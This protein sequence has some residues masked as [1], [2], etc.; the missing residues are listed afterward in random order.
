MNDVNNDI[1]DAKVVDKN[2]GQASAPKDVVV[3]KKLIS[4]E[5]KKSNEKTQSEQKPKVLE[6]KENTEKSVE[7]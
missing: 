3:P 2:S 6:K 5:V 1:I 7:T 4:K